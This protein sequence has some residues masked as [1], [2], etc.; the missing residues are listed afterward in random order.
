MEDQASL[1]AQTCTP[2]FVGTSVDAAFP[3]D[4]LWELS[5]TQLW[6]YYEGGGS[7]NQLGWIPGGYLRTQVTHLA[8]KRSLP[9]ANVTLEFGHPRFCGGGSVDATK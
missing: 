8:T 9:M 2:D 3:N 5:S 6:Q 1:G 4:A 7:W